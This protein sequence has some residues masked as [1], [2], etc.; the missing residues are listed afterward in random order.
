MASAVS[1][2]FPFR[3]W[4]I[5][6]AVTASVAICTCKARAI[7]VEIRE[8]HGKQISCV[9][10]GLGG[11]GGSCGMHDGYEYVLTGSV[12]SVIEISAMEK[13]LRLMPDEVFFDSI[14]G[15]LTV[16]TNQGACLPEMRAGDKWLFYLQRDDKTKALVLAY[17]S[18]SKPVV[19]AQEDIAMLRRLEQMADAGIIT[20][21]VRRQVWRKNHQDE[22]AP[23]ASYRVIAK[24]VSDGAEIATFTDTHGHY[25]FEPLAPDSYV[26]TGDTAPGLWAEGGRINVHPHSCSNISFALVPDGRISGQVTT[27]DG[28]PVKYAQVAVVPTDE[29]DLQ[30]T[31]D[32]TDENGYFEV[33]GLHSGQYLVGVGI[34]YQP[35]TTEW[36]SRVYYPGVRTKDL[37]VSIELGQ[38]EKRADI[39][40]ELPDS[41][42][43]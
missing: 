26:L 15:P 4:V 28:K 1:S 17:G 6:L 41:P 34:Q 14:P 24:R 36:N 29:G 10:S 25:E 32:L 5:L 27:A 43:P 21:N 42:K 13:R 37:A 23:V 12:L 22:P 20:G 31:S 38:A 7:A 11:F 8:Y 3:K 39:N 35:G 2:L 40:L 18:P 9:L 19:D 16:T 30:F 33:K